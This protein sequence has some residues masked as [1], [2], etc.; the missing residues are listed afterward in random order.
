LG[1]IGGGLNRSGA[2]LFPYIWAIARHPV[3]QCADY[4]PAVWQKPA[5]QC[6]HLVILYT[7]DHIQQNFSQ[8]IT[9]EISACDV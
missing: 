3:T 8:G 1:R 2:P 9:E 4:V 6:I 5:S 7:S